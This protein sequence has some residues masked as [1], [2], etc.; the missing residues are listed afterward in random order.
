MP[1]NEYNKINILHK[2]LQYNEDW[3]DA[4]KEAVTTIGESAFNREITVLG[5]N[6]DVLREKRIQ[7]LRANQKYTQYNT[8]AMP[9]GN[10]LIG[11]CFIK[12]KIGNIQNEI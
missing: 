1:Q 11:N 4:I 7:L 8:K 12:F 6:P 5:A 2:I 9:Y 3:S 10:L